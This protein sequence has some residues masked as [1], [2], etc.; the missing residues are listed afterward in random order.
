MVHVYIHAQ[1][2]YGTKIYVTLPPQY[3]PGGPFLICDRLCRNH[4]FT[5]KCRNR[6]IFMVAHICRLRKCVYFC[7][8]LP[9][10]GYAFQ[11]DGQVKNRHFEQK[12]FSVLPNIS[13]HELRILCGQRD[14]ITRIQ[15]MVGK[16]LRRERSSTSVEPVKCSESVIVC[17]P[18]LTSKLNAPRTHGSSHCISGSPFRG[19]KA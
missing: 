11:K 15:S 9:F 4:P 14:V 7:Q 17:S 19:K 2:N 1:N 3:S 18:P 13:F 8:D 16:S 10:Q 6:F 12:A 5:A